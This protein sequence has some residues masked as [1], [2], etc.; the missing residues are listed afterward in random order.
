MALVDLF[1]GQQWRNRH[2]GQTYGRGGRGGGRR[3]DVWREKQ[4]FIRPCVKQPA[5]ENLLW[6][7][8]NSNR[9][10]AKGCRVRRDGDARE[11]W[12]GGGR[13]APMADSYRYDRNPHNSLKQL[14]FN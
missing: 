7:P 2:R 14:S 11:A 1:S 3:V 4:K 13:R 10:S 6:D 9:G 12:E 8:G 5:S